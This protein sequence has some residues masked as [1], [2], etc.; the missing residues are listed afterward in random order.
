[1]ILTQDNLTL[2]F[3]ITTKLNKLVHQPLP[4]APP[5]IT[6]QS[7]SPPFITT[8]LIYEYDGYT[9]K[10]LGY[11]T[12]CNPYLELPYTCIFYYFFPTIP[13][14]PCFLKQTSLQNPSH[15]EK[16][17]LFPCLK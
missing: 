16:S 11:I 2:N 7:L 3:E 4:L 1:M 15:R 14:C 13:F 10:T 8:E 12:F 6:A 17:T 5:K 9:K